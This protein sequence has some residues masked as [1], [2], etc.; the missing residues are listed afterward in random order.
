MKVNK[1]Y[2]ASFLSHPDWEPA[3]YIINKTQLKICHLHNYFEVF[4]VDQGSGEHRINGCSQFIS[5]GFLCF[6]RPND[7]HYYEAMSDNFR[8][9]NIII[10]EPVVTA[11]FA[12]LGR[13]FESERFLEPGLPPSVTLDHSEITGLIREL[14]QLILHKKIMKTASDVVYRITIFN[15]LT[16]YFPVNRLNKNPGQIPKWLRWLSLE[17]L[18]TENFKKGLPALYKLSGKSQEHLARTCKKYLNKTPSQLVNVIRLEHSAKLLITTNISIIDISEECGFE[19]L[20]YY[21]HRFK[22]Y[23]SLSPRKFRKMGKEGQVYLRGDLS[24]KA[25]IPN[26]A[27]PW[28]VGKRDSPGLLLS[29]EPVIRG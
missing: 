22:E 5:A 16:K 15:I 8:I 28:E 18:K 17:M 19:S 23:Y 3:S 11:L 6:I 20:S 29:R 10:P 13:S 2:S 21:Y 7:I 24:V 27:I 26:S 25:E 12:F 9:I 1:L 4:L 14:E